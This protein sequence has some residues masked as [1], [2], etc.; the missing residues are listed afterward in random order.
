MAVGRGL[1]MMLPRNDV[2]VFLK[3]Q[4]ASLT[5]WLPAKSPI[6]STADTDFLIEEQDFLNMGDMP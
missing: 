6:D 3:K 4:R 1:G 5:H 2:A